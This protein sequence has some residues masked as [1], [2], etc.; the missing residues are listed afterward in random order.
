MSSGPIGI[1]GGTF[2]PVHKGH[3]S[4][5]ASFLG[6]GQIDEL[7]VMLTPL[8]PHKLE[9]EHVA[10]DHRLKMLKLVFGNQDRIR[11]STIEKTLPKPSYTYQ[12]IREL[13]KRFPDNRYLF[14]M[15]EDSLEKFHTWKFYERILEECKLLVAQRPG[16]DHHLVKPEIISKTIFVDHEPLDISSTEVKNKLKQGSDCRDQLNPDVLNYIENEGLYT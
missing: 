11:I 8:P 13:K 4:I 14:C 12:T 2:D 10:Y 3:E 7:W 6:S 16:A 1:F 5:A 9:S 15:G